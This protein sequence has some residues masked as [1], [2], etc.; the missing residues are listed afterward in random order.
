MSEKFVRDLIAKKG[1]EDISIIFQ[2]YAASGMYAAVTG[3]KISGTEQMTFFHKTFK[4]DV[5]R[6]IKGLEK[7]GFKVK[8]TEHEY[9]Q[10]MSEADYKEYVEP[11]LKIKQKW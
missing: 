2:P 1:K 8:T 5:T 6:L 3:T 7:D 10:Y 9:T 4:R 11:Q